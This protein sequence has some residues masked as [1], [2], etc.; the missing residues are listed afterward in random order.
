MTLLRGV[1]SSGSVGPT[2]GGK[3]YAFNTLDAVTP[4]QVAPANQA[5][6]SVNFHNPG[7]VDVIVYQQ[8]VQTTGS[9]AANPATVAAKG[10]SWV[11]FAN[12]GERTI[13]GE[14]QGAFYALAISSSGKPLT[15]TDSNI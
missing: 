11:I 8:Y 14:C 4:V 2:S 7:D 9:N 3:V 13:T 5:R 10:G 15:V 1:G 6:T 12:G